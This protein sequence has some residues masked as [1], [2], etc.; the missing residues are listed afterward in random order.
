M[1]LKLDPKTSEYIQARKGFWRNSVVDAI[2]NDSRIRH[3]TAEEHTA[4]LSYRDS[5]SV[6]STTEKYELRFQDVGMS[7]NEGPVDVLSCTTTMEVGVDIGSLVAVGLRNVPPQR[8]NYQQRAGRSG[9]RGSAI[10]SVITYAQNGPHDNF[11]FHNP[12]EIVAGSPRKP[13]INIDNE[14][15]ARRHLH[16]YLFQTFFHEALDNGVIEEQQTAI[17][18]KAL[19]TKQQ[20]FIGTADEHPLFVSFLD[21]VKERV[22]DDA[23]DLLPYITSWL[24]DGVSNNKK[25]WIQETSQSLLAI[26]EARSAEIIADFSEDSEERESN[27]LLSYLFDRGILPTYA[28]PTDL[29]SFLVEE[30][31]TREGRR[32]VAIKEQPQQSITKALS[33]YAPGRLLV[34]DKATYRVG[35]VTSSSA[36]ASEPNRAAALFETTHFYNYCSK[37]SFVQDT[38]V[39]SAPLSECPICKNEVRQHRM[40]IPEAFNPESGKAV[41]E[42]DREQEFTYATS[43][44]FPVP[45]GQEDIETWQDIG[46]NGQYAHTEDQNLVMVNKGKKGEDEDTGFDI[47]SLCGFAYPHGVNTP[48]GRHK[49]PYLT[50]YSRGNPTPTECDGDIL[51]NLF[52]GTTF[53]TDLLLLRIN[54]M[55]PIGRDMLNSINRPV[56]EDGLRSLAEALLLAASRQ[57]DID[58]QE[59]SAGFRIFPGE[60]NLKADIYLY[61]TLSGGAGYA[62]QAGQEISKVINRTFEVLEVCKNNCSHSCQ[63]CL[64]HYSNQYW[65]EKLDRHLAAQFLHFMV[66]GTLPPT[67]DLQAQSKKLAGLQRMLELDGYSCRTLEPYKELL[68]PLIVEL[69]DRSFAIGTYPGILDQDADGFSHPLRILDNDFDWDMCLLNE[70]LL[71]QNIPNAYQQ[72]RNQLD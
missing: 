14:K 47:C 59:F 40:I 34:I 29:C 45:V 25:R 22:V 60:G 72:V 6:Y 41:P 44:Q 7:D 65:H 71:E 37:C 32:K 43:A 52:L 68:I 54:L 28:F 31:V 49:R 67:T 16:S 23:G 10:S 64:R 46:V 62:D 35:G 48:E 21:W 11:Y 55:P 5:G 26:L 61:D 36:F 69:D 20:F 58:P 12:K 50:E 19:G 33:E 66:E 13:T 30:E 18:D 3:I 63:E 15:I 17:I 27:E 4:Q 56:I 42:L 53:R 57:L 2:E 9:R 8:E 70:Y 39:S 51:S 24:P 38:S 1:T